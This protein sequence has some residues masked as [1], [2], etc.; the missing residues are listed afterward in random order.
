MIITFVADVLGEENNGT[1]TAGQ[2]LIRYLRSRGHRV[3]VVCPDENMR[4]NEDYYIV[5]KKHFGP[6]DRY[7][8]KNGVTLSKVDHALLA[9]AMEGSDLVYCLLPFFL[10]HAAA[11]MAKERGLP[12]AAGFHCQAENITGHLHLMNNHLATDA[13]Y[14]LLNKSVYRYCDAIHYPSAFICETFEK[15][16][17][18]TPHHIISNGVK[19]EFTAFDPAAYDPAEK[20][21]LF[22]EEFVIL[23]TG[24][25]SREKSHSLLIEAVNR[26]KY[27]DRIR[28]VFAGSGPLRDALLEEAAVLP[29]MPVFRFYTRE[30]QLR[31]MAAVDLYV[32]PAEIEI[33]AIAC[34]EAIACGIPPLISDSP[35]SATGHFALHADDLF[36]YR[37]PDDLTKKI[38]ARIENPSLLAARREEYR[39]FGRQFRFENCMEQMEAMLTGILK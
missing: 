20:K 22:G 2:N 35:R 10:G 27:R 30:E 11:L 17:G 1:S 3:K 6:F 36:N 5:K 29:L 37:D 9:E 34:L 25:Y 24:R 31:M 32:H 13:V 26:S 19:S 38:D 7:V 16:V 14:R 33:E 39:A 21:R 28:L 18:P 8:E 15:E 12:L 23:F 4:G